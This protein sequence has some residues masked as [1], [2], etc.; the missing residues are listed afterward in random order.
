VFALT[1]GRS[2]QLA[3]GSLLAIEGLESRPA[4][5]LRHRWAPGNPIA[6]LAS[7]LLGLGLLMMWRR[8]SPRAETA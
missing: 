6:L 1:P 4:I 5:L 2:K 7:L 8:F 3:D